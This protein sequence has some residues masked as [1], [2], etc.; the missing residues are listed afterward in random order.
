MMPDENEIRERAEIYARENRTEIAKE[1]ASTRLYPPEI[2]PISI[3]MAGSPGAGKTEFS[4]NLIKMFPGRADPIRIDADDLRNRFADYTGKNSRLFQTATSLIVERIH[5]HALEKKQSF[6]LDG[7]F[8]KSRKAKE[9]IIRSLDKGRPTF[10]F[11][12]YDDPESAWGFTQARELGEGRNIPKDAFIKEFLGARATVEEMITEFGEKIGV[13]LVRKNLADPNIKSFVVS[14]ARA[15]A[16]ID[17]I[18]NRH[19]SEDELNSIL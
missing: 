9:N 17:S 2:A 5:D 10:I 11:Y 12:V 13:L 16:N 1:L 19:Y 15:N 14:M 3:F 4:R 7:T 6:I 8:S 18:V